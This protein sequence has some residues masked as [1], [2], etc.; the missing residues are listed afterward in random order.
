[1]YFRCDRYYS[2]ATQQFL[3]VKSFLSNQTVATE[4]ATV[5]KGVF[6]SERKHSIYG[7]TDTDKRQRRDRKNRTVSLLAVSIQDRQT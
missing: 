3:T 2:T 5:T 1:M 6:S 4:N 7:A